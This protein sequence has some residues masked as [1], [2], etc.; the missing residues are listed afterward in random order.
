[1]IPKNNT[2]EIDDYEAVNLLSAIRAIIWWRV[3]KGNTN[4]LG[5]LNSGDWLGQL[6][7]KLEDRLELYP[8]NHPNQLVEFH[9]M[10][11]GLMKPNKTPQQYIEDAQ[12]HVDAYLRSKITKD[13]S[14]DAD[15]GRDS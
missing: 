10:R 7:H 8:A 1:M 5:I 15:Q 13:N 11:H 2:I 3:A 14:T 4:P 12:Q 6:E 9:S